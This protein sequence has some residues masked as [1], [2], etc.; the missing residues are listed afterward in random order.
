LIFFIYSI[1]NLQN[2]VVPTLIKEKKRK[3]TVVFDLKV[4]FNFQV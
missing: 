1:S 3:E 4:E 2:R